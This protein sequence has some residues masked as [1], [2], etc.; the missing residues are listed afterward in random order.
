LMLGDKFSPNHSAEVTGHESNIDKWI[1]HRLN[2]T[3]NI[4]NTSLHDYEIGTAANTIHSFLLFDMCD[5]YFEAIKPLMNAKPEAATPTANAQAAA[6]ATLY[7]IMDEG[8]KLIHPFMPFISEELWQRFPRRPG[9]LTE[10]ICVAAFPMFQKSRESPIIDAEMNTVNKIGTIC[11]ALQATYNINRKMK[12]FVTINT[13]DDKLNSI[14]NRYKDVLITLSYLGSIEITANSTT[15]PKG[16]ATEVPDNTCEVYLH[17]KG[18]VDFSQERTK[19]ISKRKATQDNIDQL[20]AKMAQ[21][22][23]THV[24]ATIKE[25]NDERLIA[26]QQELASIEKAIKTLN[27]LLEEEAQQKQ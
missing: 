16:C 23:Y 5:V 4:T 15:T 21:S 12:P 1:L 8:L 14:L 11:R 27:H 7:T 24:P 22:D 26:L 17:I 2:D 3:I 18:L 9:D 6:C 13:H 10:S 20:N 19:L 25:Q